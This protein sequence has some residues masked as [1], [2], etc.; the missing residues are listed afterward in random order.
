[1][2]VLVLL[3]ML[4]SSFALMAPPE[5]SVKSATLTVNVVPFSC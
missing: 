3:L 1:M 5:A 4:T 2:H